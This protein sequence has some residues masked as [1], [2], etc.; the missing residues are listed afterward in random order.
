MEKIIDS[1]KK[2]FDKEKMTVFIVTFITTMLA[3]FQL[4]SLILTGPDTLLSSILCNTRVYDAGLGR[5][6]LY[7]SQILKGDVVSPF[8]A[9]FLCAVFL[10]IIVIL[11]IDIFKI[12]NKY[13]K[14]LTA[15]IL[16]VCPN[17][18]ATL[19][20]F[21]CS[22]GYIFGMLLAVLAVFIVTKFEKRNWM[23]IVGGLF[24]AIG[25]GMYQTYLAVTMVLFASLILVDLLKK[26][27]IKTIGNRT[28][29]YILT[30]AIG[31]GLYYIFMKLA[32]VTRNAVMSDYSGAN[33]IGLSTLQYLPMLLP[34]TYTRFLQYFFGEYVVPNDI[35]HTNIIYVFLFGITLVGMAIIIIENKIYKRIPLILLVLLVLPICF[36]IIEIVV[37]YV[38]VHVLM[39]C[40]F[41]LVFPIFFK[42]VETIKNAEGSKIIKIAT[43]LCTISIIWI[44]TWQ[45]N[46]TYVWMNKQNT[47][48]KNVMNRI[49][50]RVEELDEYNKDMPILIIGQIG[51]SDYLYTSNPIHERTW[52]FI[53]NVS[54]IWKDNNES[55]KK[56][57]Y[58]YMGVNANIVNINDNLDILQTEEYS[59][60]GVYPE[61][62][63]IKII[64]NTVV[65]KLQ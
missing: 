4:Y 7:Y 33:K 20:F 56:F 32:L 19:T 49:V 42:I 39:G 2:Y 27:D 21:F 31:L 15:L 10:G 34:Q 1:V 43:V 29:K 58:E 37:P 8:L 9:T 46:S 12:K 30:V 35:W 41:I 13:F 22:D 25:M 16:A 18:S 61:N 62:S 48:I 17:I 11:I 36:G 28:I 6:S 59:E 23:V 40:S 53:S 44:Y 63:S 51:Y 60:M 38:D 50:T 24:L 3:H 65:I 45:D 14:I 5:F 47:Q 26:E 52:G 54:L 55:W 64:N 57:F